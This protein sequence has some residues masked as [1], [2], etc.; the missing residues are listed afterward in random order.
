[1]MTDPEQT[2][3]DKEQLNRILAKIESMTK[4]EWNDLCEEVEENISGL[5]HRE[6]AWRIIYDKSHTRL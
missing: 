4:E 2:E 5:T 3:Y 1:M 6:I